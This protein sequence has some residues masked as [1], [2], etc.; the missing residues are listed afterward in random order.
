MSPDAVQRKLAALV[1]ADVVGYSRLMAADEE[2]TVRRLRAYRE[3]IDGLI[4]AH[5]GRVFGTAGDSVIAEF[6]S[7]TRSPGGAD[8]GCR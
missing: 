3:I 1:S 6:A 5:H 8:T 7:Q 2:G 4:A